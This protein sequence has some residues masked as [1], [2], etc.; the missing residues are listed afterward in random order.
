MAVTVYELR[1]WLS[2]FESWRLVG[3]TDGALCLSV[4]GDADRD[5]EL[6]Y[7]EIGGWPLDDETE[8]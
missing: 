7:Y 1:R 5:S 2:T 4:D 3:I 6:P 8:D